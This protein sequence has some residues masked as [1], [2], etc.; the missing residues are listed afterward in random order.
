MPCTSC[1]PPGARREV[2]TSSKINNAPVS[3]ANARR[4]ARNARSAG[5]QPVV[6]CIGSIRIAAS[7]ARCGRTSASTAVEVVVL[8][9]QILER[10]VERAAMAAEIKDAAMVAA[11]EHQDLRPAGDRPRRADRHQIGLGA[12][13]G[14]AHQLDRREAGADRRGKARLGRIVRAEIE[15]LIERRLDRPADRRMR[16]AEDARR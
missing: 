14:E 12:G 16:M 15:A 10:R 4:P 3:L 5:M 13:I 9:E 11:L 6:P 2:I 8:P 7:S 1:N